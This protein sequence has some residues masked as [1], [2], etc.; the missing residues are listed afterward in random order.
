MSRQ[1]QNV[2]EILRPR[3]RW[4]ESVSGGGRLVDKKKRKKEV[5]KG[6][7]HRE[8]SNDGVKKRVVEE[9]EFWGVGWGLL[10]YR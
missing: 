3:R 7:R 10:E 5:T 4:K 2:G 6:E 1:F 8:A 9:R